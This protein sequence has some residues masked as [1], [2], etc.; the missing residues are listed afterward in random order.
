MADTKQE[1]ARL[2]EPALPALRKCSNYHGLVLGCAVL[3]LS[4][5]TPPLTRDRLPSPART[6]VPR[7]ERKVTK[8]TLD[9]P[10]SIHSAVMF[11]LAVSSLCRVH[12]AARSDHDTRGDKTSERKKAVI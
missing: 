6:F 7:L 9:A 3:P 4:S 8:P 11:T 10:H 1:A 5:S 12:T 2:C